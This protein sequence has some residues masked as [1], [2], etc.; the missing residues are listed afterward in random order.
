MGHSNT[1]SAAEF[2]KADSIQIQMKLS[3]LDQIIES[4]F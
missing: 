3:K 1:G 4:Q 2:T